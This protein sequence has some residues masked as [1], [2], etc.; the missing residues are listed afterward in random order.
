MILDSSQ[1]AVLCQSCGCEWPAVHCFSVWPPDLC[2]SGFPL[3]MC[4]RR[5]LCSRAWCFLTYRRRLPPRPRRLRTWTTPRQRTRSTAISIRT[6]PLRPPRVTSPPPPLP[7]PD[8][9]T[10]SSLWRR[11]DPRRLRSLNI[12]RSSCRRTAC[13]ERPTVYMYDCISQRNPCMFFIVRLLL[14]YL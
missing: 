3:T 2:P 13:N 11:P 5:R 7:R 14:F 10:C 12:S 8:T 9:V 1:H 6:P 4:I